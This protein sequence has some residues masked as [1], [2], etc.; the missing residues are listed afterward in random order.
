MAKISGDEI[1]RLPPYLCI[2][3]PVELVWSQVKGY[4]A[5]NNKTFKIGDVKA[6]VEQGIKE[7]TKEKWKGCIEHVIA[8]EETFWK[9]NDLCDCIVDHL[10]INLADTSCSS[11]EEE[12]EEEEEDINAE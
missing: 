9:S 5:R 1:L 7:V 11:Y 10:E 6:L 2:L 3:N 4:V 12:E 8:E